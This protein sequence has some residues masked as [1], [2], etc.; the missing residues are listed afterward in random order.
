MIRASLTLTR[1]RGA[2]A[3]AACLAGLV[4]GGIIGLAP[5]G[6]DDRRSGDG[7]A[8]AQPGPSVDTPCVVDLMH[9]IDP[10]EIRYKATATV[11]MGLGV[12]CDA[13]RR[14]LHVV[15]VVDASRDMNSE[16]LDALKLAL[17]DA[18][19]ALD[20]A[21]R[22]WVKM[23]VI[24]V[25]GAP[26]VDA[27]KYLVSDAATVLQDVNNIQTDGSICVHSPD[28][29]CGL[30][31]GLREGLGILAAA[32]VAGTPDAQ[33]RQVIVMASGADHESTCQSIR[34][35]SAEVQR[36]GVLVVTTCAGDVNACARGCLADVASQ[37][38]FH[39]R[40]DR[41]A[42]LDRMLVQ[43]ADGVGI[44]N[45]IE[46]VTV[47]DEL[48]D[49]LLFI[50]SADP[51]LHV[52]GNRLTWTFDPPAMGVASW[53][54][55]TTYGVQ[56]VDCGHWI[57]ASRAITAT[58]RY[59]SLPWGGVERQAALPNPVVHIPC[60]S[61]TPS[62]TP[63][64]TPTPAPTMDATPPPTPVGPSATAS[65]PP[66]A[67]PSPTA[68]PPLTPV[69][70]RAYLPF[71]AR[72]ACPAPPGGAPAAVVL[73]FDVSGSMERPAGGSFGER[74]RMSAAVDLARRGVL[75]T[76]LRPAIDRAGVLAFGREPAVV[77][78]LG[79]CCGAA[80]A[81]LD[82]LGQSSWSFPWAA[83]DAAADL[84]AS[85]RFRPDERRAIVLFTDLGASDLGAADAGRLA[86]SAAAARAAGIALYAVGLG[87]GADAAFLQNVT[88]AGERV[89]LPRGWPVP[90]P[91]DAFGHAFRC[92]G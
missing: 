50:G 85:G 54:V 84:L 72:R 67:T 10:R 61:A 53:A 55:T 17:A 73:A 69:A 66:T 32:R 29:I 79:P 42:F 36:A 43:L 28:E 30:A 6:A 82:R 60:P 45:P 16:Q 3:A 20:L 44:F 86:A 89:Y 80:A 40:S 47:V 11:T 22:Q 19:R 88:G 83:I 81:A 87:D 76:A 46:R 21:R 9:D 68:T 38:R 48:A 5:S 26:R 23:A 77:A 2:R 15:L 57:H 35:Q 64:I 71:L 51:G 12:T 18:V 41:W 52:D 7:A 91:V 78:D 37:V 74:S 39:L 8:R 92:G 24:P 59:A 65:R 25:T 56:A 90:D 49:D 34:A 63:G 4:I 27:R 58:V 13:A 62:A 14:P 1:G 33:A 75:D 31:L 70:G